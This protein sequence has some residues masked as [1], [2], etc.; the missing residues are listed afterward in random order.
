VTKLALAVSAFKKNEGCMPSLFEAEKMRTL[1]RMDEALCKLREKF[2][3]D[4]IKT[5]N[6]II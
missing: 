1:G 5:A 2:G 6:E 3:L 4:I